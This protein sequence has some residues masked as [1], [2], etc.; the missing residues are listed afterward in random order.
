MGRK[1]KKRGDMCVCPSDSVCHT[2]ETN[3]L[4]S[5]ATAEAPILWPPDVKSQLIGKDP[6]ARL[7]A[8]GEEGGRGWDGWMASPTQWTWIWANSGRVW[9]AKPGVLQSM[10]SPRVRHDLVTEQQYST[11]IFFKKDTLISIRCTLIFLLL[12]PWHIMPIHS[13]LLHLA[14]TSVLLLPASFSFGCD[15]S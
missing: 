2:A 6:D 15:R 9:T 7:K 10:R 3:T 1:S 5:N 4:K 12:F 11:Q 14:F 8:K 13:F